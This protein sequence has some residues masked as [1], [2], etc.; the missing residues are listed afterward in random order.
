MD[1]QCSLNRIPHGECDEQRHA[2]KER[3]RLET[4]AEVVDEIICSQGADDAD[5][6]DGDPV[7]RRDIFFARELYDQCDGKKRTHNPRGDRESKTQ[8][9]VQ[10]IGGRLA[11]GHGHGLDD[12][13]RD[14]DFRNLVEH[15]RNTL[16][17][18]RDH[19]MRPIDCSVCSSLIAQRTASF[20][21]KPCGRQMTQTMLQRY[22]Q[23]CVVV[24]VIIRAT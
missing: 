16:I 10:E 15:G 8:I 22:S 13:E 24:V 20:V 3:G 23:L 14:S 18:H 21:A 17:F 19:M 1:R 6:H 5:E 7:D 2:E 11:D 12:P 9:C 4:D